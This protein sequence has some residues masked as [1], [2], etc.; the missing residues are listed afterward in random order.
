MS[1][2]HETLGVNMFGD[3]TSTTGLAQAGRR[4]AH[5]LLGQGVE[6]TCTTMATGAPTDG[7]LASSDLLALMGPPTWAIDLWT[8]NINELNMPGEAAAAALAAPRR[9]IATWYWELA[10]VPRSLRGQF[11]RVD[12]I[13]VATSF[14]RQSFLRF[15]RRP[16]HIVPTVVPK[17]DSSLNRFDVRVRLGIPRDSVMFLFTFDFN[18]SVAR[19]NPF[20]V[21]EA[22]AEAFPAGDEQSVLVIKTMN[23]G[24][25]PK[26]EEDLRRALQR[27]KGRLLPDFLPEQDQAD[28]F[29]ACDVYVSMHRSEGFGLGIAEAMALG[30]P[31]IATWYSGNCDFMNPL[32]SCPVGYRLRTV[33]ERDHV[34]QASAA[35]LYVEGAVWAEPEISQAAQWMRLLAGN[36]AIRQRIG[37]EAARTMREGF[38]E[39][40]VGR[41]A[42]DR[43]RT[44]YREF[45]NDRDTKSVAMA[46]S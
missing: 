45:S 18:S 10:T 42:V 23:L 38:S 6:L 32:N 17:F 30:K 26:F 19:K 43:L 31:V 28:L 21:I 8:L 40:A 41:I 22:F 12:E 1:R 15:T 39:E 14:V 35:D 44:S 46:S 11:D 34:Y 37:L 29:H 20:G 7:T 4:L 2:S 9:R 25:A 27:V 36:E 33:T 3:W 24:S 16:I 5:A 13:W